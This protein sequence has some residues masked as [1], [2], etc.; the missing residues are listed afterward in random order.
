MENLGINIELSRDKLI[1]EQAMKLLQD[2]YCREKEPSPQYAFARAATCY[3][4]TKEFAQRIYDYVSK[5]WFMFAFD[6]K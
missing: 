3:S 1:T 4:P 6:R 2:Y 5:G